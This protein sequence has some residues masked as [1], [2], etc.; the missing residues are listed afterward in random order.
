ME[1]NFLCSSDLFPSKWS[2]VVFIAYMALFINQGILVTSTKTSANTFTYNIITV[3]MLTEFLK[4]LVAIVIYVKDNTFSSLYKEIVRNKHV[5]VM[6]IVPA[7]LYSLYN[8][9]QFVNL[10]TYDPTT[11]YVLLQFRVVVTGIIFQLLFKKKLSFIQWASICLLTVGC[12]IKELGHIKVTK[13]SHSSSGITLSPT[14]HSVSP[15]SNSSANLIGFPL[16]FIIIQVFSSCFAGVYNEYL[17]KDKACNVHIMVQNVFMYVQS[18]LC[19]ASLLL[20]KGQIVETFTWSS[21]VSIF[22]FKVILIMVNNA[23]IGIIVSL[24]LHYLNSILKTFASALEL[25]FTAILCWIIFGIRI[26]SYTTISIVIVTLATLLYTRNPVVNRPKNLSDD[27]PVSNEKSQEKISASLSVWK[28]KNNQVYV[29]K[30][31]YTS[32]WK[33]RV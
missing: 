20:F 18:I 10:A 15:N 9:L 8:N 17:L 3:V 30:P 32:S 11:Y 7:A 2:V 25:M 26:D 6:Y 28:D 27:E 5:F 12:I 14:S 33:E 24:F 23:S 1:S 29:Q 19:N 21:L 4:L 16:F 22:Q 13:L 31:N